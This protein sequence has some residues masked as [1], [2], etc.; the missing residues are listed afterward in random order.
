[1]KMP[2]MSLRLAMAG[3][4][5]IA[6]VL[7][8]GSRQLYARRADFIK[9]AA[10]HA[11]REAEEYRIVAGFD[12]CRREGTINTNDPDIPK[13][14][15]ASRLRLAYHAELKRKYLRAAAHPWESVPPDPSDPGEFLLWDT[16]LMGPTIDF[17]SSRMY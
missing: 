6:V 7:G 14:E 15:R 11:K 1:M 12:Q 4:A 8:V 10:Y 16:S 9:D 5:L 17:P 2:S 3:V 13:Y